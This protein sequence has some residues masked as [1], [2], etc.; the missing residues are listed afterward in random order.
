MSTIIFFCI[1]GCSSSE[2]H[3]AQTTIAMP[4]V[5]IRGC[6]LGSDLTCWTPN[7]MLSVHWDTTGLHWNHTGWC[8][9]PVVF[10]SSGNMH[11]WNTLE[12]HWSYMYTGMPLEQHWLMMAPT[13]FQPHWITTEF[14]LAQ[15]KGREILLLKQLKTITS[16]LPM[17]IQLPTGNSS[18]YIQV[19]D[20]STTDPSRPWCMEAMY[21]AWQPVT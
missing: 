6:M 1:W 11:N 21:S 7:Q 12:D 5:Y 18:T 10:Q 9:Y 15:G 3:L 16:L 13:K 14:P 20:C 4:V 19:N 17:A 2:I 8:Y